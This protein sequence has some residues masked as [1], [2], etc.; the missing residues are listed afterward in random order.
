MA[1]DN[2]PPKVFLSVYDNLRT[3]DGDIPKFVLDKFRAQLEDLGYDVDAEE[4]KEKAE[5]IEMQVSAF[6]EIFREINIFY[7]AMD[8]LGYSDE[9]QKKITK[10]ADR[11]TQT[12]ILEDALERAINILE[13]DEEKR[14]EFLSNATYEQQL[15]LFKEALKIPVGQQQNVELTQAIYPKD[16]VNQN[17][18]FRE[19]KGNFKQKFD[20]RSKAMKKKD[21]D[22]TPLATIT[23]GVG[24]DGLAQNGISQDI[25]A[26]FDK[27]VH[28]AIYSI[29]DADQYRL[30]DK[31]GNKYITIA[32]IYEVISGGKIHPTKAQIQRIAESIEK[33]RHVD[34][35][36]NNGIETNYY[37]KYTKVVI[38]KKYLINCSMADIV[39]N[40]QITHNAILL[41]EKPPLGEFAKNRQTDGKNPHML[42]YPIILNRIPNFRDTDIGL[43]LRGYLRMRV[44]DIVY[45]HNSRIERCK[46]VISN[47]DKNEDMTEEEKKEAKA[48]A[49]SKLKG[50]LRRTQDYKILWETIQKQ[51]YIKNLRLNRLISQTMKILDW[52]VE[53]G[54]IKSY[55]FIQ[56][57]DSKGRLNPDGILIKPKAKKKV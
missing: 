54:F 48:K 28:D 43:A 38:R 47:I 50:L 44:L 45:K 46:N 49:K 27:E 17:I 16:I 5:D 42:R 30:I 4:L 3:G 57:K 22:K 29:A 20:T 34:I 51:P 9:K 41:I 55:E 24:F 7:W 18:W 40:G 6:S 26:P 15:Q 32:Q 21:K 23:T 37:D 1:K 14:E 13:W 52:Y 56:K 19:E 39:V 35:I 10:E 33:M 12:K 31:A 11:D 53:C 2:V 8:V 25:L 36:L